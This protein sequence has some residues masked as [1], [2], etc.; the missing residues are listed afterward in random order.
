M[1]I[2]DI[3]SGP[4]S[5]NI[6]ENFGNV[7]KLPSQVQISQ[8]ERVFSAPL[9]IPPSTLTIQGSCTVASLIEI[10]LDTTLTFE[11]APQVADTPLMQMNTITLADSTPPDFYGDIQFPVYLQPQTQQQPNVFILPVPSTSSFQEVFS[12]G[13]QSRNWNV[14]NTISCLLELNSFQLE[15]D[16]DGYVNTTQR[17]PLSFNPCFTTPFNTELTE[18]WL[19]IVRYGG[20]GL[21]HGQGWFYNTLLGTTYGEYTPEIPTAAGNPESYNAH[22][23]LCAPNDTLANQQSYTRSIMM[24]VRN[25]ALIN[26][27]PD[28]PHVFFMN[29][30]P[31]SLM[32]RSST[33]PGEPFRVSIGNSILPFL[34]TGTRMFAEYFP[35]PIS[36][37]MMGARQREIINYTQFTGTDAAT[38]RVGN[39]LNFVRQGL[40]NGM[41]FSNTSSFSYSKEYDTP[42]WP[43][44][45]WEEIAWTGLCDYPK[46]MGAG[47]GYTQII[48]N[49]I[50]GPNYI[51]FPEGWAVQP[52]YNFT[53]RMAFMFERES[54]NS[55]D[56]TKL[57]TFKVTLKIPHGS[58]TAA[59]L[60]YAINQAINTPQNGTYPFF[61]TIDLREEELVFSACDDHDE[62]GEQY[63]HVQPNSI[64]P[65]TTAGTKGRAV[66]LFSGNNSVIEVGSNNFGIVLGP[67]GKLQWSGCYNAHAAIA[68]ETTQFQA[69]VPSI[70]VLDSY[71]SHAP[72]DPPL[73]GNYGQA[74]SGTNQAKTTAD[75][76]FMA[77]AVSIQ[78][79]NLATATHAQIE[80]LDLSFI[81]TVTSGIHYTS[82]PTTKSILRGANYTTKLNWA[83]QNYQYSDQLYVPAPV[84]IVNIGPVIEQN[85]N[86]FLYFNPCGPRG[87]PGPQGMQLISIGDGSER[88]NRLLEVLGFDPEAMFNFWRPR[89]SAVN[90]IEGAAFKAPY[91]KN[92]QPIFHK[93]LLGVSNESPD[94]FCKLSPAVFNLFEFKELANW[95]NEWNLSYQGRTTLKS[96]FMNSPR[97]SYPWDPVFPLI[98]HPIFQ[99]TSQGKIQYSIIDETVA[100][101]S[102]PYE[103][104]TSEVPSNAFDL[105]AHIAPSLAFAQTYGVWM[106]DANCKYTWPSDDWDPIDTTYR[107]TLCDITGYNPYKNYSVFPRGL[108][109]RPY[110]DTNT[111]QY[112]SYGNIIT[113]GE[114]AA[115]TTPVFNNTAFENQW[116]LFSYPIWYN[117]PGCVGTFNGYGIIDGDTAP[118]SN[119]VCYS[120]ACTFF[121]D[122]HGH[123][124]TQK[125]NQGPNMNSKDDDGNT[126]SYTLLD[127]GMTLWSF[128]EMLCNTSLVVPIYREFDGK[129]RPDVVGR[130]VYIQGV[131][132]T[133]AWALKKYNDSLLPTPVT[134][135]SCN[136]TLTPNWLTSAGVMARYITP[137]GGLTRVYEVISSRV[138]AAGRVHLDQLATYYYNACPGTSDN[139]F[140]GLVT[141]PELEHEY[142]PDTNILKKISHR[143]G[144]ETNVVGVVT[145]FS[146]ND[147]NTLC[148]PFNPQTALPYNRSIAVNSAWRTKYKVVAPSVFDPESNVDYD[149][150]VQITNVQSK[151]NEAPLPPVINE[152]FTQAGFLF[153]RLSSVQF[154]T[155]T[156]EVVNGTIHR[157]A[158]KLTVSPTANDV[159]N[160]I[161]FTAGDGFS[162]PAQQLTYMRYELFDAQNRP[163]ANVNNMKFDLKFTFANNQLTQQQGAF[164]QTFA[165]G[166]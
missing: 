4:G 35:I 121:N 62:G 75:P 11:W 135:P 130:E 164:Q 74:Q 9:I 98:R 87:I 25:D 24:I 166:Q 7:T 51:G 102:V 37:I 55:N 13:V 48:Y 106:V 27:S 160:V 145:N 57:K 86:G 85:M 30:T 44:G 41:G 132:D 152:N 23:N 10:P 105:D 133:Y 119:R 70:F 84:D 107:P 56:F 162:L 138:P 124:W 149:E 43:P 72:W 150:C 16:D 78:P 49:A 111:S 42:D 92:S 83:F 18:Q 165:G 33:V 99:T 67:E 93:D 77:N 15:Y 80:G 61:R 21:V 136:I 158:I 95:Q 156:C 89:I 29:N 143:R 58:Y 157:D 155:P 17:E 123:T 5:L 110:S 163:I 147:V 68:T 141:K 109:L 144:R 19:P 60:A 108:T 79:W 104:T 47:Y 134:Y 76:W 40:W 45:T 120:D 148:Y 118:Y 69:N 91:S 128:T 46:N 125:V 159:L 39:G 34:N 3:V 50:E 153:M 8:N 131:T 113:A 63:Q 122:P 14:Y 103:T 71:T 81:E 2:P 73:V 116:Q 101:F 114:Y 32:N 59:K 6:H 151:I 129:T 139:G 12:T 82:H 28:R 126:S 127:S 146:I 140:W 66:H 96:G 54:E 36:Q 52:R 64:Y 161:S 26:S 53:G 142:V 154:S 137:M 115:G 20:V 31:E 112:Y 88:Q 65:T 1:S 94:L 22:V 97:E 90:P 100:D 117:V 38:T